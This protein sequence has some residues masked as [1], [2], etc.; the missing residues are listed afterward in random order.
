M[1]KLSI[2][3]L[4]CKSDV[5]DSLGAHVEG[6]QLGSVKVAVEEYC[7]AEDDYASQ[8]FAEARPDIIL[9][10]MQDRNAAMKTM[11]VLHVAVPG[12]L[13]FACG[14]SNEPELIIE[15]MQ[16]GAR[17]FIPRPV[18]ARSLALAFGRVLDQRQKVSA[19]SK[20]RG[21]IYSVT[22]GKGGAGATS[23]CLN[24]AATLSALPDTRVAIVDLNSPIG[25]IASYL[26]LKP[27]FSVFDALGAAGRLDAM[28]L[29]TYMS[30][31]GNMWVLPSPKKFETGSA[32]APSLA[33]LLRIM[34]GT[35]T[36]IF[37]DLPSNL[38]E[39]LLQLT[40]DASEAVLVVLTP[41]LPA[42]WRTH[43]M[44][45][46]LS[47]GGCGDRLRLVLNRDQSRSEIDQKE[48]ARSLGQ[49]LFW[50]LPNSYRT[51]IQAINQGRPIV[52]VN[53][54]P[55]AASYRG[56]TEKLT[57]M[58]FPKERSVMSRFFS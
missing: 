35:Y 57:G 30:K 31:T 4:A 19:V 26:N 46:L 1:E 11:T 42:L 28:L 8:R 51:A 13:L 54:S 55:L 50:N 48:I 3:I 7:T 23:V 32:T 52:D 9:I 37:I 10:D 15:T 33:K 39:E 44:I 41:E 5:R 34:T 21:K 49:P 53:H 16:A 58:A 56:L 20:M 6:T 27:Q 25:D 24:I 40:T 43:R 38:D 17:E 45:S 29:D 14:A 22:S 18:S 2:G 12:A 47:G 36:H